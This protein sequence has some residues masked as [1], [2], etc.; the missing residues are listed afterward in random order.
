[1]SDLEKKALFGVSLPKKQE[2]EETLDETIAKA[3]WNEEEEKRKQK[4]ASELLF[5]TKKRKRKCQYK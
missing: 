1:M 2:P 4:L 5:P 3:I